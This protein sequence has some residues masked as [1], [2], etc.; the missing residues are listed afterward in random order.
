MIF[1]ALVIVDEEFFCSILTKD[2]GN[3]D[4][5]LNPVKKINGLEISQKIISA[6]YRTA[7][8]FGIGYIVDF[9]LGISNDK[10]ESYGHTK[11][12]TFCNL[13]TKFLR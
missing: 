11:L 7:Q 8:K 3:C 10:M 2:C 13:Q 12:Q 1:A 5:C 9:L 4:G 6:I